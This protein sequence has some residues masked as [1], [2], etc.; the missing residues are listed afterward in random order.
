[1]KAP[2]LFFW[3][4]SQ[5]ITH[6]FAKTLISIYRGPIIYK[7]NCG[8][9]MPGFPFYYSSYAQNLVIGI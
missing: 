9:G 2:F 4:L 1:M 6:R 7:W 8:F 3:M 5:H